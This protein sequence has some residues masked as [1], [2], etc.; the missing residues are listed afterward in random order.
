MH[1][2]FVLQTQHS[3]C[4]AAENFTRNMRI[5]GRGRACVAILR[6]KDATGQRSMT[7]CRHRRQK[8][9]MTCS[10]VMHMHTHAYTNQ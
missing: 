3:L 2:P 10:D 4:E 7:L 8:V 5:G 9:R 1:T 6:E